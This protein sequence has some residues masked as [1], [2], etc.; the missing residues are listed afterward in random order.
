MDPGR[1]LLTHLP[2]LTDEAALLLREVVAEVLKNIEET[3]SGQMERAYEQRRQAWLRDQE[4]RARQAAQLSLPLTLPEE[5]WE[6][7]PF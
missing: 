3:Y 7:I 5:N 1:Y 6:D 2:P 4:R